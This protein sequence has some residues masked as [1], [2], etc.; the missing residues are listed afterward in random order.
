M[1]Q[2]LAQI[3]IVYTSLKR[4][5]DRKIFVT[6]LVA[7]VVI[8]VIVVGQMKRAKDEANAPPSR[9]EMGTVVA[10]AGVAGALGAREEHVWGFAG[11]R[12]ERI[13]VELF[14]GW[15]R[16][17]M[18]MHPNGYQMIALDVAAAGSGPAIIDSIF[19]STN[20]TYG[21]IVGGEDGGAGAYD[22]VVRKL[23]EPATPSTP[24]IAPATPGMMTKVGPGDEPILITR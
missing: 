8:T 10:A 4:P 15:D 12:G 5:L 9:I 3:Y 6:G 20:G 2:L 13:T 17:L 23:P 21:I 16:Q 14:G 1:N 22:L 18:V 19:L 7:A 24:G 11:Q